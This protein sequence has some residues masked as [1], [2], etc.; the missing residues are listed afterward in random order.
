M[1][2]K[3]NI[4]TAMKRLFIF[5]ILFVF[6]AQM[7]AQNMRNDYN[8][9][10]RAFVYDIISFD[11]L[12]AI[13]DTSVKHRLICIEKKN[14]PLYAEKESEFYSFCEFYPNSYLLMLEPATSASYINRFVMPSISDALFLKHWEK[15]F[16]PNG[17][18]VY[19]VK[20]IFGKEESFYHNLRYS[21]VLCE[22]FIVLL[23][24]YKQYCYYIDD[25]VHI[26]PLPNK[27][28]E[29]ELFSKRYSDGLYV[30]IL[31]PLFLF[32]ED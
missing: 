14:L 27:S 3:I 2:E 11:S 29:E 13:R 30:K 25:H 22:T 5:V 32:E 28:R 16:F 1:S 26:D 10:Q 20:S 19:V 21:D 23:V 17:M 6:S 8:L 7:F 31:Y 15:E 24:P 4:K 12:V 9:E 18:P